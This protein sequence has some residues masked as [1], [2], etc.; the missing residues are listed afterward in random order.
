MCGWGSEASDECGGADVDAVAAAA[1]QY[2]GPGGG[3]DGLDLLGVVDV[4]VQGIFDCVVLEVCG[5]DVG[6]GVWED[7]LDCGGGLEEGPADRLGVFARAR[8]RWNSG[9]GSFQTNHTRSSTRD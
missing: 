9:G 2:G 8:K 1:L 3:V 7:L 5:P 4:G 6:L